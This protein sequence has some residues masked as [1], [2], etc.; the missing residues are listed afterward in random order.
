MIKLS[1]IVP[2]YNVEKYIEKCLFS[3]IRQDLPRNE[4]EIIVVNDGS[5]DRSPIIA[6]QIAKEYPNI[7]VICYSPPYKPL[8]SEEDNNLIISQIN[9]AKPNLLWI[10]MTA[11]KQE[12]WVYENWDKLDIDCHVGTIGAVFDFYAGT[13]KRAPIWWQK[14]SL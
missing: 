4:Y 2:V 6:E 9:E 10:G 5:P 11:P 7:K 12:K 14:H 8:F 3:C 13:I 1:I